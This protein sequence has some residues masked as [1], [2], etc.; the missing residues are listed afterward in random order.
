MISVWYLPVMLTTSGQAHRRH[1]AQRA[2]SRCRHHWQRRLLA[3]LQRIFVVEL[4]EAL[5]YVFE[6]LLPFLS[7]HFNITNSPD[8][9][10]PV[11]LLCQWFFVQ[12]VAIVQ[13]VVGTNKGRIAKMCNLE[14]LAYGVWNKRMLLASTVTVTNS[15]CVNSDSERHLRYLIPHTFSMMPKPLIT[16]T[17]GCLPTDMG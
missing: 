7:E 5:S 1:S 17:F 4:L 13:V 10:L 2:Q 14:V 15:Q 11:S 12:V 16:H 9:P 6:V 3:D 8:S